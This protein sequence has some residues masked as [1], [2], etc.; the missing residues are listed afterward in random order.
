MRKKII[1]ISLCSM[2]SFTCGSSKLSVEKKDEPKEKVIVKN[3]DPLMGILLSG[4]IIYSIN[5]LFAR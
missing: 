3:Q 1:L 2:L 5:I 4:L